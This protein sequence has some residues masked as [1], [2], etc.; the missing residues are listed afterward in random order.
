MIRFQC[1]EGCL[2]GQILEF[3]KDSLVLGRDEECDVTLDDGAC[4]RQH[5]LLELEDGSYRVRDLGSTNGVLV[6]GQRLNESAL[7]YGDRFTLGRN[8][9][10]FLSEV[11]RLDEK[12]EAEGDPYIQNTVSIRD[13]EERLSQ[14]QALPSHAFRPAEAGEDTLDLEELKRSH[15]LMQAAY[16]IS[17]AISAT[18]QSDDLFDLI[19]ENV[20]GSFEKAERVSIFVTKRDSDGLET[21]RNVFKGGGAGRKDSPVSRSVLDRVREERIGILASDASNDARFITSHSV[22]IQDLRSLMC[23]PLV[24]RNRFLGA[25]Y[26]ENGSEPGCF[27]KADLELLTLFG[28]QAAFAIEN[29][30]LYEDLQVSFYETV[31][32]LTNALEAKD[33]YTRGH[34]D[35]VAR[36]A[37]AIGKGLGLSA[38]KLETL[39]TAAELHDIGKIA[40]GEAIISKKDRLSDE[41]YEL[42]KQHPQ[43]GVEIL[44]PIRF[45]QPVLPFILHHHERFNGRGYPEGL[46]GQNIPLE[47]RILN[48]ADA[49]DAMT[50]QRPY[51]TPKTFAEALAQCR[52]EAGVSFDAECVKALVEFV[53][54]QEKTD[55]EVVEAVGEPVTAGAT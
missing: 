48:L 35:R 55:R 10:V 28:N 13:L 18:L 16:R 34:S 30:L 11:P 54:K 25:I 4:S 38:E 2:R 40:I 45:L 22:A 52:K 8:L 15:A 3:D 29:A 46:R 37:V 36:Y 9:F 32:S 17:R 5:A 43:R 31:R 50:T 53:E 47:A 7:H 19:V 12:E 14:S 39:R 23:V 20:L 42:V 51:N 24:T 26:V 27:Q 21:V 44:R 49:F 33:K 6:N 41:E 1:L